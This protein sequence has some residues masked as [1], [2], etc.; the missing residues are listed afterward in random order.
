M[1]PMAP[2]GSGRRGPLLARSTGRCS[3]R[4]AG[5]EGDI[6]PWRRYSVDVVDV[7]RPRLER[8]A[9]L[10]GMPG[11]RRGRYGRGR[12]VGGRRV[13]VAD[14]HEGDRDGGGGGQKWR[15]GP[16]R[17]LGGGV[18]SRPACRD[19]RWS[20][21]RPE[22]NARLCARTGTRSRTRDHVSGTS[23]SSRTL[24][25]S[26]T[27]ESKSSRMLG[28]HDRVA[29]GGMGPME[30]HPHRARTGPEQLADLG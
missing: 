17:T 30:L 8:L 12:S 10:L 9:G 29:Q 7:V 6:D 15:P 16:D 24:N 3:G 26:A 21:R 22:P 19:Q 2:Q 28:L 5:V 1:K 23:T 11:R 14:H 27:T 25:W 4:P 13:V 20:L 18:R